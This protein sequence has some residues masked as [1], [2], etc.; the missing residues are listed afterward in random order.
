MPE[1]AT[2]IA[3]EPYAYVTRR[4]RK[5]FSFFKPDDV[6]QLSVPRM[7]DGSRYDGEFDTLEELTRYITD[8]LPGRVVGW[9]I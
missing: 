5:W 4:E 8:H 9:D 1:F 2:P 7:P 3:T 6:F